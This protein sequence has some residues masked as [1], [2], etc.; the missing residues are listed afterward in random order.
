MSLQRFAVAGDYLFIPVEAAL[1][2]AFQCSFSVVVFI[3]IDKAVAF[4]H[5]AGS[6]ADD[7]NRSPPCVAHDVAAVG[8]GHF[9]DVRGG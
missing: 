7:I 1:F 2:T 3:D 4:F 8:N 6:G 9:T 5:L